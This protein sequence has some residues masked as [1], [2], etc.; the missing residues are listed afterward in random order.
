MNLRPNGSNGKLLMWI[1]SG[2]VALAFATT[3]GYLAGISQR[4]TQHEM[5]TSTHAAILSARGERIAALE[6]RSVAL[7][8]MLGKLEAALFEINRKLDAMRGK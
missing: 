5:V 6:M 1:L 3:G 7:E 4:L 2:L 8:M